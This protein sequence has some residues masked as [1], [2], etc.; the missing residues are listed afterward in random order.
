M[1]YRIAGKLPKSWGAG[2]M[3][4][5]RQKR[6]NLLVALSAIS[7]VA[8]Y[9]VQG[10]LATGADVAAFPAWFWVADY[11]LWGARALVE[12]AVIVYL[13]S[14]QART[15]SQA[16]WLTVF[17]VALIALITLTVGP[18]LR[19]VGLGETMRESL[20][21]AAF[22]AWSFGIAAYT[23]LMIGAAG[24]AYRCQPDDDADQVTELQA[25]V[26]RMLAQLSDA[27][28]EA[29]Q[30]RTEATQAAEAVGAW[31]AMSKQARARMFKSLGGSNGHSAK[32][33]AAVL[34]MSESTY[35][36]A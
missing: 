2:M 11:C 19:A 10:A 35:N 18:A 13:F 23:S 24:F 34:G 5:K 33:A 17:E 30:A 28:A 8:L 20:S 22:T 15:R 12:A 16:V 6:L 29:T 25:Q 14:T 21:P 31:D 3:T 4:S 36:R 7:A 32:E 26:A 27:Q 1:F 9:I